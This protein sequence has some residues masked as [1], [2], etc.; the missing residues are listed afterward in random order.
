MNM[1]TAKVDTIFYC[2]GDDFFFDQTCYI[3]I[4][5]Y[6]ADGRSKK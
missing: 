2:C 3:R 4:Y 5:V 1:A 6:C